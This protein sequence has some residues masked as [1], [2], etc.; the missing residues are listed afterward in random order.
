[1]VAIPHVLTSPVIESL[2]WAL[3]HFVWQA[4]LLAGFVAFLMVL[5]RRGSAKTR[6]LIQCVTLLAMVVS[7]LI[8]WGWIASLHR[9]SEPAAPSVTGS[10]RESHSFGADEPLLDD[11]PVA[12]PAA[13][14]TNEVAGVVPAPL[15]VVDPAAAPRMAPNG[16]QGASWVDRVRDQVAPKLP[17]LVGT[18]FTGVLV[19][20]FRLLIGWRIVQR[21]KRLATTPAADAIQARLKELALRLGVTRTVRLV[22]SALIEVP[23]VIGWIRPVILLPVSVVTSLTSGQLEAILAHELAH[24]R[25]HDYLVNLIQTA[26]ETLLFYHPAVWWLSHLI[27]IEREHCCDDLAVRLCDN[28]V[29]Y[30]R[31]L[32]VMEELRAGPAMTLAA[33]G[34][35]LLHRIRRIA[36]GPVSSARQS[37]RWSASLIALAVVTMLGLTSYLVSQAHDNPPVA[38]DDS[39]PSADSPAENK[40]EAAANPKLRISGRA[41]D[42]ITGKVIEN[43]R[44]VPASASQNEAGHVTWQSQYLKSFPDGRFLYETDRPWEKTQLR[45]EADGYQPAVTRAVNKGDVVELDV[46]L[47]RGILGGVV[48]LPDGKPAV[49]AQVALA[50]WTNEI[51]ITRGSLSYSHHGAKLRQIVETDDQGRFTLPAEVD[52]SVLIVAHAEGYGERPAAERTLARIAPV[53]QDLPGAIE[54]TAIIPLEPWGRVEGQVLLGD[55]PVTGAKYWVYQGRSDD[56]QVQSQHTIVTDVAGRFVVEQIPPGPFGTCQRAVDASDGQTSYALGGLGVKF[57]VA[58]GQTTRLELGG[59]GRALTGMLALPEGFP[60]KIDWTRVRLQVSP[61]APSFRLRLKGHDELSKAWSQFLNSDEGDSYVRNNIAV[62][63][64]GSFQIEG[65]PPGQYD[66][67]VS[68][69]GEAAISDVKPSGQILSGAS[70]FSVPGVA[71]DVL[72]RSIPL[73]T[74]ELRSL[75]PLTNITEWGRGEATANGLRARVIPV[76][77]S[78]NEDAI[79]PTQRVTHFAKSDDVAFVVELENVGD[80]PIKLLDTRYGDGY[81]EAKGKASSDWFGQFLFSF[82]LF[83]QAGKPI[84][85]PEVQVV[86]LDMMLGGTLVVPLEPGATHRYLLRPG[87]WQSPF[88]LPLESGRYRIAVRYH[89][90]PERVATR[91][92][93][94]RPASPVLEAAACNVATAAVPIEITGTPA[95]P[96]ADEKTGKSA[97]PP[98]VWGD[99]SNGLRAAISFVPRNEFH[100]H[101]D[102][103]EIH[104]HVQNVSDKPITLASQ[105]WLSE[106]N[107]SVANEQGKPVEVG[108]AWY[109]GMT[110]AVRVTLQP[111]QIV[112]FG[113]GNIGLA[114]TKERAAAFEHVT[115]RTLVAPTGKYT[116]Q[117]AGRFGDSFLLKDGKGKV[118][119]PLDGDYIG[120]LKSGATP[121]EL[122]SEKI[123]C[124]IVDAITGK[125]VA[126]TLVNFRFFKP[127][128]GDKPEEI[129]SDM[130]WGPKSPSHIYF[131]IPDQVLQRP[132]REEIELQWSVSGHP[133]Y[134]QAVSPERITLK[135]FFHEGPKSAREK[136]STIKLIP[137]KKEADASAASVSPAADVPI[138]KAISLADLVRDFNAENNRLGQGLDQPALTDEEVL[139]FIGRGNWKADSSN[140]NEQEIASFRAIP[141]TKSVPKSS[142]LQVD[143]EERAETLLIRQVWRI[144]L[145]LP[146][147]GHDGFVGLTIRDTLV[148]EE[149]VDPK[150]IAWGKPDA[151]GLSLGIFLSPKQAEYAIGA[152][153][154]LRLFVRNDGK[155]AVNTTWANSTHPMPEDF[156][157]T[158]DKGANVAVRIGHESWHRPWISGYVTGRLAAGEIHAFYV[159]YEID[160]GG[161]GSKNKL[162]GRVIDAHP[163]QKLHLKVRAD[164]GNK[165]ERNLVEEVIEPWSGIVS[166]A[167]ARAD[168]KPYDDPEGAAA[169]SRSQQNAAGTF[170]GT[171]ADPDGKP[172]P[173]A[174]IFVV[175]WRSEPGM[176]GMTRTETDSDGRFLFEAADMT[177]ADPEGRP[178]R[179]QGLLVA[180][181][182]GF[183]ADWCRTWGNDVGGF[184]THWTPVEGA[185]IQLRL[186]RN[187]VPVR[188]RLLNPDGSP[189]AGARVRILEV[190]IPQSRNL[191]AHLERE[192][193]FGL[194]NSTDYERTLHLVHLLPGMT[195]ETLTDDDG[196]F[197]LDGIGGDRLVRLQISAPTVVDTELTAMARESANVRT[198]LGVSSPADD[199]RWIIYGSGFTLTLKPGRTVKGRVI[200][201]LTDQPISGMWVG[202]RQ[203]AISHVTSKLYPW[204]TD[205]SGRFTISGLSPEVPQHEIAAIATPG[206]PYQSASVVVNDQ[207]EA[208]IECERGIPFELKLVDQHN[209]PVDAEVSYTDI[210]P[211]PFIAKERDEYHWPVNRALKQDNGTYVGFALPGPGAVLIRLPLGVRYLPARVDPKAFFAPGTIEP[212]QNKRPSAF[213][214][215]DELVISRGIY[216]RVYYRDDHISQKDF[217]AI[218]LV[219]PPQE[220]GLLQ[221]TA[222]V[223]IRQ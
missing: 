141:T 144:R 2:G 138:D 204:V 27:R 15:I 51:S 190:M 152:R 209:R 34:G 135:Q 161:D 59:S 160:I 118:L 75:I 125:P 4:A 154:R 22:E 31:A 36:L 98:L 55:K 220:S 7:P 181:A 45:I 61:Q 145:M 185:P 205:D 182:S 158:D 97:H 30:V 130:F 119:A 68:V 39:R 201:R 117:L 108:S 9:M 13:A 193:K 186:A 106:L 48:R 99:P 142:Y 157:A 116:I 20:S 25:R 210:H 173:G 177:Y 92:K 179:R 163:G 214:N 11:E 221:L 79:D 80:K 188:G 150:Q 136:L 107:A 21:L 23:T 52:P 183:A 101:G 40:P 24:I 175:P 12:M 86:S 85:Q 178:L 140:L 166:V 96:A 71:A 198:R 105:L 115:N 56:V 200:D 208:V 159:P 109:S 6:Y 149:K 165:R 217:A 155:S 88:T 164:N 38:V 153:V 195:A 95:R 151:E 222:T 14:S 187:D 124:D 168:K 128:S 113:A 137:K 216:R 129:V 8:T 207:T 110:P 87:K 172:I 133:D 41:I 67:R 218:V 42:A 10:E 91:I 111:Q 215:L 199:D 103:P 57:N 53:G 131:V 33:N 100:A 43:I 104:W 194:E 82:D 223:K 147:I 148:S 77:S 212:L 54:E 46:K 184:R 73:D 90:L 60:H 196:R 123:G 170:R 47:Q 132:D 1:M 19:L 76:L 58:P 176:L 219:N 16:I 102:K 64:D 63:V 62:A 78:M 139:A 191:D 192:V 93:E 134:E 72:T 83:D 213:G 169:Q 171:V 65:L 29:V 174:R 143:T 156:E 26:I 5:L 114:I 81:G 121:F 162:I 37:T 84:Q 211:N 74:I 120:E 32:A 112:V 49:K 44:M 18:W 126:G 127:K 197:K 206:L 70:Q 17:W 167:I 146:A 203:N 28:P 50:T 35:S 122:L 66:L 94:Y 202:P 69:P 180:S 3:V 189:L 89:G